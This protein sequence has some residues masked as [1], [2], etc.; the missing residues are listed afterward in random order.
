MDVSETRNDIQWGIV[1]NKIENLEET[2]VA[3]LAQ[4]TKI[5]DELS[6]YK[7][8]IMFVK[9]LAYTGVAI[10]AFKFGDLKS[11]WGK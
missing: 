9:C 1:L 5:M 11:I 6:L 3:I 2:Q 10:V 8:F 7:H 4:Q